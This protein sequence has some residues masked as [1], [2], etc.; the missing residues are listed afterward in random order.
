MN[1]ISLLTLLIGIIFI[2]PL[3][4]I[5]Y[6]VLKDTGLIK[7]NFKKGI[8]IIP[9]L[10]FIETWRKKLQD[11]ENLR[12]LAKI[13]IVVLISRLFIFLLG[14]FEVM[15]L[16]NEANGI[17]N[18]FQSLWYRWDSLHYLDIAQNW[19]SNIGEARY[20][21][22]FYPLY[23]ILIKVANFLIGNYFLSGVLVSHICLIIACF[24]LYKLVEFEF[25][26]EIADN[27]LKY[28]LIFPVSF[29]L[30]IVFTDSLFL[31]LSIACFYYFRKRKWII[32][33]IV[34]CLASF[35]RNFG[36]LLIIPALIEY[37][38]AN[39][40]LKIG[41]YHFSKLKSD[42]I[43]GGWALF[44]IPMGFL[45]YLYI[46]KAVTGDWF[47]FIYYESEHWH[48]QIDFFGRNLIN[49]FENAMTWK[50]AERISLWI[51]QLVTIFSA[52]GLIFYSFKKIPISY[53]VYMFLYLLICVS[54]TWLLSGPRYIMSL[55][56]IYISIA[57]I[58]RNK[59]IDYL[60]SFLLILLLGFYSLAFISGNYVM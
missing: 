40:V 52:L 9:V 32:A 25:T 41:N 15:L 38:C 31:A 50:P 21:I 22:V 18:S 23:P 16:R 43:N 28:L 42:F 45:V 13:I 56:P 58:A 4:Y 35:T 57:L 54:L 46:N 29:F 60:L 5:I 8:M 10:S 20:N 49:Y 14:Y 53:I 27:A 59:V 34:G 3:F 51:P 17:V 55:F 47:K 6:F 39:Q 1:I 30:G 44:L 48:N 2:L 24:Y 36:I 19:Y 37:L 33:G 12:L 7:T 26:P 11:N